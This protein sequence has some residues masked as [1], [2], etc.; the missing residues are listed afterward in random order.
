MQHF[1]SNFVR[2]IREWREG[3]LPPVFF[4]AAA[5]NITLI[6]FAGIWSETA[7]QL[8][9]A[10][11]HG[12]TEHF[13]WY[14]ITATS[15]MVVCV[16]WLLFSRH[17]NLKLGAQNDKP[18]YSFLAWL[19]MLFAAGMGMGLVFWGVAEPLHH[20]HMP[21]TAEPQSPDAVAEAM[22]FSY[23]HWGLHPWAIYVVF[24]LL[25]AL[26]HFRYGM[27][28]APRTLLYPLFGSRIHGWL[29]H[30][31]DAFCT[32][33]TLIGVATSLG[34]G[35]MQINAG[36]NRITD[37][38]YSA[39][40]QVWIITVITV[41]ATY[42]TVSGVSKGIRYLSVLNCVL[43]GLFLVFVFNAGPTAYQMGTFVTALSDYM[44]HF[45]PDSLW[46]DTR[47]DT[48]WQTHWTIFYWGWWFSWSP[49]VGIFIA[50]ISKGRTVREFVGCVL[51]IPTLINF[52]WF[53]VFGGTGLYI[54]EHNG[55]IADPVIENVAM[56]L[57][58]LLE[59]LPWTAM[60]QW[61]GL[62][63]VVIFFITS[64]D[65]G[66]FVDDMVTSGGNPNPPVANRV[67]WG[68]SEG[69]AAAV[70]LMA[71]GLQAL[72]AASVSAGLPQSLLLLLGCVGLVKILRTESVK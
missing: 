49:F 23:F 61:A 19:A 54:E 44:L 18:Q 31:T 24:G 12:I 33:G 46:L 25:I 29:G 4:T 72:Q 50:R 42:S 3:I 9:D 39:T 53:A 21:P 47:P 58:I 37:I 7:G 51:L 15:L 66:S 68:V 59:Y 32:V 11:L 14:Y 63:L 40:V 41:V 62:I 55:N 16:C 45:V 56:S 57:H 10:L 1:K 71:G 64:S 60:M 43:M 5:I 22:R 17:G 6:V 20:Y 13:D 34:L 2:I 48:D 69:A 38:D 28:L 65:S 35:A 30:V 36:L 26:N 27:P 67:F 52:V 8:F 70:L